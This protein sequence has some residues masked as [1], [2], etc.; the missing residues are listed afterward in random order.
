MANP[1]KTK[2]KQHCVVKDCCDFEEDV[3]GLQSAAGDGILDVPVG[4]LKLEANSLVA[5]VVG[6][7]FGL[8]VG[9]QLVFDYHSRKYAKDATVEHLAL[10]EHAHREYLAAKSSL[11]LLEVSIADPSYVNSH[12]SNEAYD[13]AHLWLNSHPKLR[14]EFF[15]TRL[16]TA[17][18]AYAKLREAKQKENGE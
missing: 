18:A 10:W 11:A 2:I 12:G 17:T 8:A 4:C 14:T 16:Q 5:K 1:S 15:H 13:V 6:Y 9:K 7:Y 3:F